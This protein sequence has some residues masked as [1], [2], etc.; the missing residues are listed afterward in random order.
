MLDLR[1]LRYFA[2]IA[3]VG[4]FSQAARNL[5]VSQP[6]LSQHIAALETALGTKLFIRTPRGV[7]LTQEGVLL[8]EHA[9][10]VLNRLALAEDQMFNRASD[11]AGP[12]I[13]VG[14]IP[15]L[16]VS[17]AVPMLERLR[18]RF[19]RFRLRLIDGLSDQVMQWLLA[20]EVQIGFS[21]LATHPAPA[22]FA[23]EH[24]CEERLCLVAA[25]GVVARHSSTITLAEAMTLPLILNPQPNSVR[26][27]LERAAA[28]RGLTLEP[29][30]EFTSFSVIKEAVR[31][32][33]GCAVL[34]WSAISEDCARGQLAAYRLV[35]PALSRPLQL[36]SARDHA[37]SHSA[38]ILKAEMLALCREFVRDGR[39]Q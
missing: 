14:L 21:T 29:W 12:P 4:S 30:L 8:L 33:F 36:I 23:V 6:A 9:R 26:T 39:F 24:I 31:R 2:Q 25:P 38:R 35:S 27:T 13:P 5:G 1:Q 15:S 34:S 22:R 37:L 18:E 7:T 16:S 17:F 20:G 32:G 19:P 10:A 3:E 28:E 11:L